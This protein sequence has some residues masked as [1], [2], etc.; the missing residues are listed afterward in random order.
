[1]MTA[2]SQTTRSPLSQ[3]YCDGAITVQVEIYKI[4]GCEGWTLEIVEVGGKTTTWGDTFAT[5]QEAFEEFKD[6]VEFLGLATL[7]DPDQD[8]FATVH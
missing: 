8:D 5:D 1:M 4:F 7:I 6:G 2:F 3:S